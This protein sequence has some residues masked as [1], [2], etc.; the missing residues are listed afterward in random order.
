MSG[1]ETHVEAVE[2]HGRFLS[3]DLAADLQ[4]CVDAS[5]I[6]LGPDVMG[7]ICQV[8]PRIFNEKLDHA[9]DLLSKLPTAVDSTGIQLCDTASTYRDNEQATKDAF[10][11]M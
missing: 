6:S 3:S 2:A 4:Q 5:H 1:F 8:Y 9:K 11:G 10:G 7:I